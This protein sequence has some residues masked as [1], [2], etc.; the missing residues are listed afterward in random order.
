M[1]LEISQT[2]NSHIFWLLIETIQIS[3]GIT[4]KFNYTQINSSNELWKSPEENGS[5]VENDDD[6]DDG[7]EDDSVSLLLKSFILPFGFYY[8][9]AMGMAPASFWHGTAARESFSCRF[10]ARPARPGDLKTK[11]QE[12]DEPTTT[13]APLVIG[14]PKA[15]NVRAANLNPEKI[16]YLEDFFLCSRM[17]GKWLNI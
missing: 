11:W 3:L 10:W 8:P 17:L 2:R 14:P 6:D 15:I 4:Q 1:I 13:K 16:G 9:G 12:H 7:N 5:P